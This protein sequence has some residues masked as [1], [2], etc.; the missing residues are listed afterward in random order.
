MILVTAI[1]PIKAGEGKSTT[2]ISLVD[3]LNKINKNVLGCLREPSL[4]PVFG[5]KGAG[6]EVVLT[7]NIMT[8]PGLP[9]KPAA[10]GMGVDETG[11]SYG[12]F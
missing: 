3:G 12:I 5:L 8:L 2:T 6:F 1:T 11:E 9:K 4:G 10:L 7:G